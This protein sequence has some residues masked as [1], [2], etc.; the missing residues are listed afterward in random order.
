MSTVSEPLGDPTSNQPCNVPPK[1]ILIGFLVPVPSTM[2]SP[3][4]TNVTLWSAAT[5]VASPRQ[6]VVE[7]ALVPLFSFVTGRFPV[8]FVPLKLTALAVMV[9]PDLDR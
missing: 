5:Q 7:L 8:T 9:L 3:S 2:P 4:T 6:N 1:G